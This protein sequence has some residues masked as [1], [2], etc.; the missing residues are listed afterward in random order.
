VL[1]VEGTLDSAEIAT[2]VSPE[3]GLIGSPARTGQEGARGSKT[4]KRKQRP[5]AKFTTLLIPSLA[6]G[7]FVILKSDFVSGSFKVQSVEH[8]GDTHGND[9]NSIVEA[10]QI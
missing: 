5:G 9:W 6:P 10:V 8:I 4:R 7:K 3:T 1:D 2:V